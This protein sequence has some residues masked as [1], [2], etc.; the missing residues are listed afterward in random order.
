MILTEEL[1]YDYA[2][3]LLKAFDIKFNYSVM[4]NF[5]KDNFDNFDDYVELIHN[6]YIEVIDDMY[7]LLDSI[8]DDLASFDFLTTDSQRFAIAKHLVYEY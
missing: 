6:T 1:V 3:E 8:S 4:F 2:W 5:F 7:N